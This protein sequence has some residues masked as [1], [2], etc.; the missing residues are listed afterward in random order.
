MREILDEHPTSILLGAIAV[1]L[2]IMGLIVNVS[3]FVE[4][5]EGWG[6]R[7]DEFVAPFDSSYCEVTQETIQPN[8]T[9]TSIDL[10]NLL[11]YENSWQAPSINAT[12]EL[13]SSNNHVHARLLVNIVNHDGSLAGHFTSS[14]SVYHTSNKLQISRITTLR[15]ENFVTRLSTTS[16]N[17]SSVVDTYQ[18]TVHDKHVDFSVVF[19]DVVV[20][21]KPESCP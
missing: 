17:G 1:A 5:V 18:I 7:L 20:L 15:T 8:T 13:Y 19:R 2:V 4:V 9:N 3:S 16:Y 6:Q 10:V 12:V 21:T 14:P 11:E